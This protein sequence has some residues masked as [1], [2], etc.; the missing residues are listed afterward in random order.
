MGAKAVFRGLNLL[1]FHMPPAASV[2]RAGQSRKP[3]CSAS[4]SG[5]LKKAPQAW[6]RARRKDRLLL[7][8][9]RIQGDKKA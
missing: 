7:K 4:G 8:Q 6:R 5:A 3:A 9:E 1:L 2:G